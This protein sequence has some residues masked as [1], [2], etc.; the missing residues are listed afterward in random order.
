MHW[1]VTQA[2][3]W[4]AKEGIANAFGLVLFT[5]RHPYTASVLEDA[6]FW[7]GLDERSGPCWPI[8]VLKRMPSHVEVPPTRPGELG[9]LVPVWMEPVENQPLLEKLGLDSS[10]NPHLIIYSMLDEEQTLV[11]SVELSEASKEAAYASLKEAL[12]AATR[13]IDDLAEANLKSAEGVQAALDLTLTDL[14][15]RRWVKKAMP[16]LGV[17]RKLFGGRG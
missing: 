1:V 11:Q 3:E 9:L 7:R 13:A 12:D 2:N 10:E 4:L 17:L 16:L 15:Q 14:K 8:F 5:D 6:A